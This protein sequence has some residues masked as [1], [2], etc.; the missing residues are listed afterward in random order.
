MRSGGHVASRKVARRPRLAMMRKGVTLD[1]AYR[2]AGGGSLSLRDRMVNAGPHGLPRQGV[3]GDSGGEVL[4]RRV[5]RMFA[6]LV[7]L[8]LEAQ[9]LLVRLDRLDGLHD[10]VDPVLCFEVAQLAR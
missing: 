5:Q 8:V 3:S 2:A 7:E 10:A 4:L 9:A 6:A 1:D